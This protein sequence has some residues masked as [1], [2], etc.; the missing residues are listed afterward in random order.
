M[1]AGRR[2]ALIGL[3]I[4]AVVALPARSPA[5][6]RAEA[7]PIRVALSGAGLLGPGAQGTAVLQL[8]RRLS[9][10]GYFVGRVDGR[11]GFDTEQA[12]YAL[13]KAAHLDRDGIVGPITRAALARGAVP[14]PR[15][16]RGRA[17]EIDLADQLLMVVDGD[18]LRLIVNTSTGG[19]YAYFDRGVPALAITPVGHFRILRQI[20]G[21]EIAPLGELWRP[22]YFLGGLAIHGATEVPPFA[23]SHGCV[24]VGE[25]AMNLIWASN[26][27]PIGMPVW[28]Y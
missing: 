4:A 1:P 27:A 10:L 12:V 18:R 15:P 5:A 13:Q 2:L 21:L 23:V 3:V 16:V 20:N 25:D 9:A 14:T 6:A 7:A 24:R 11:F 22:K 8:Q 19:G 26:L 17:I 28:I